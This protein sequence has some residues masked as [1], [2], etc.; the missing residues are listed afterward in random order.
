DYREE[1]LSD[2]EFVNEAEE[3]LNILKEEFPE[4]I[5]SNKIYLTEMETSLVND[6]G[7]DLVHKD[8][9]VMADLIIKEKSSVNVF[10]A[11]SYYGDR[12]YNRD[13]LLEV[14]RQILTAYKN[15][16][17]LPYEGKMPVVF[18]E[19]DIM[20]LSKI[21]GELNGYKVG[22]G[23]SLFKDYI[24]EKKFNDSFTL[25]Q[26]TQKEDLTSFEFFDA[27][28]VVNKDFKYTLIE[29]GK[30]VAPYTDKKTSHKFNLPLTGSA[31]CEYD[32]VPTLAPR[33]FK[34]EPSDKTLRELLNRQM[35]V[36]VVIASGG[37]FTE[38]GVFGTPVQLAFLTDGERLIG[39]LPEISL[40]GELY[41]MF[42]EDY[43]GKSKDE[44]FFGQK[45]L[46]LNLDVKYL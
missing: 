34:V 27:E 14:V 25:Y 31:S 11:Y 13:K 42:G 8:R 7:L 21:I 18:V 12:V 29:K 35:A 41:S 46:A 17:E 45:F 16:V 38:E 33:N 32:T 44:P 40:S 19:K 4:F 28:G 26:S 36:V 39:K 1:T 10:D 6:M 22:T 43:I 37:D 5:F 20:P 23:A 15:P 3:V 30:I 24:G 2:E 9:F